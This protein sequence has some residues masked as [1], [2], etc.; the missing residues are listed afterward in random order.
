VL[1]KSSALGSTDGFNIA[2]AD[3]TDRDFRSNG[4]LQY[5]GQ[6]YLQFAGSGE[7]FLKAG[8]DSPENLLAY[9]DFD[10]TYS[11]KAV[12]ISRA[13]E[14][15]TTP[16][17][18]WQPHVRDWRDGDPTWK[19]S[20]GKGLIGALNYLAGKGCNAVSFLT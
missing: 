8:A 7:Y 15:T 11:A 10:A 2:P 1:V 17:K 6:R 20:K 18:T 3:K 13:N 9:A 14:A 16:L 4:R 12:G 19:D 5:V